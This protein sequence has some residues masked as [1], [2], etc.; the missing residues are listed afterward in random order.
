MDKGSSASSQAEKRLR[1]ILDSNI[2]LCRE[3]AI[4][5]LDYIRK[6]V[7]DGA[8]VLQELPQPRLMKN[9]QSFA[10]AA[11]SLL[12]SPRS[13]PLEAERLRSRLREALYGLIP[14]RD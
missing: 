7:A 6:K 10:E 14:D 11:M 5:A 2:G 8:P 1:L 12:L 3:D 13:G 9:Y 4:W